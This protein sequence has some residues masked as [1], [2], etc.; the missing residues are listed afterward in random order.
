MNKQRKVKWRSLYMIMQ[1][2]RLVLLISIL[3]L[4]SCNTPRYIYAPSVPNNPYFT[5]KGQAKLSAY[6][7][8]G[9]NSNPRDDEKNRGFDLQGAYAI[10]DN[11]ALTVGYFNRRERDVYPHY[12]YNFFD[13][14]VLNYKRNVMDIGGGY[15]LPLDRGKNVSVN[16]FGGVGFG[17]FSFTDRG[18]D[19]SGLAYSRFHSSRIVK[20]Y[21]QPSLNALPGRYFRASF[22]FKLS[23]VHYGNISTSYTSDELNYFSLDKI[24]GKTIFYFEP[25]FNMQLGIPDCDWMKIDGGLNFATDPYR[26]NTRIEARSFNAFIGLCFDLSALKK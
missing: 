1:R 23:F 26:N 16:L 3:F 5:E 21:A 4:F 10:G 8:A 9:G 14:S 6:Y 11:W 20:W 13:S 12:D 2:N 22:I 15:F 19:K 18:V 25:A 7:S 17:K 24:K